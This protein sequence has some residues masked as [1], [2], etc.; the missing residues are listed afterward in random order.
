MISKAAFTMM[1]L[2]VH[3]RRNSPPIVT[4]FV[5]GETGKKKPLIT[6]YFNNSSKLTPAPTVTL[7]IPY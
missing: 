6:I 3:I 5:P 7:A 2:S 1:V 4:Y